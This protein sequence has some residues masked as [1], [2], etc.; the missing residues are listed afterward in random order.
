MAQQLGVKTLLKSANLE[1][2]ELCGNSRGFVVHPWYF[3][4]K[5]CVVEMN[6]CC[7]VPLGKAEQHGNAQ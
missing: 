6:F 7:I 5:I 4:W 1:L 2:I 3:L